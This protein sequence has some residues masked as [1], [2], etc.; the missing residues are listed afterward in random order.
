M[1]YKPTVLIICDGWGV[2]PDSEGNA[3]ARSETPN[4][5]KLVHN[6]PVMT[7]HASGNEV[8]LMFGEMG[9]SEVGHLN[10]GAGRIYYQTLPRINKEISDGTF[11]S[12]QALV[13]AAKKAKENKSNLHLIGLVSAGN[14]HASLEHL[15]ALLELC[16]KEGLSGNQVFIHAILDGRDTVFN[17]G[18]EFVKQ[19]QDKIKQVKVGQIATLSGRYYAMDRDNRWDRVEKAYRTIA[20]GKAE[21]TAEDPLRAIDESY[22]NKNY[23]EEFIPTVITKKGVPL[24]TIKNDDAVIFFNF[25]PDRAREL[26]KALILPGFDKFERPY[27]KD[28]YFVTMTEYEKDLPVV[29]ALPPVIVRNS[30]AEVVSKAGLK[31][32]HV[33]ETEKYA[34]ITFFLNGTTEEP[35]PGEQ[36]ALVPSPRVSSYAEKP[37]M[38]AAEVA[39]EAVKAI[40]GGKYD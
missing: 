26:T 5:D 25:R 21:R 2:A 10:I 39:K 15:F 34:H 32:F 3:I 6:Y 4:F 28:L 33:A 1:H 12:N 19:L 24:T 36:R 22:E 37:E 31:Q 14:V 38:S 9:N 16:K 7:L 30:L 23:D 29:V 35:F 13:S 18:K 8:G 20:E 27:F 11:F 40:D 17:S